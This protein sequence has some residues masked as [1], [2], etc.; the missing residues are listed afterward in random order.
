MLL[1]NIYRV[2]HIQLGYCT[3]VSVLSTNSK[4]MSSKVD[5]MIMHQF[6]CLA[7]LEQTTHVTS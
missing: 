6:S 3:R 4:Q 5:Y 2:V 7:G 1:V